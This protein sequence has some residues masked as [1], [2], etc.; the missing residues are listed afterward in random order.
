MNTERE[1]AALAAQPAASAEPTEQD[2]LILFGMWGWQTADGREFRFEHFKEMAR[3]LVGRYGVPAAAQAPA[4]AGDAQPVAW[5]AAD[6]L[7]S[8]H[9]T[10]ISSLAYMS[11]LD[12]ER[13]REYMPLYTTDRRAS[14]AATNKPSRNSLNWPSDFPMKHEGDSK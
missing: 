11:Q 7:N 10:C 6:T 3:H 8:P 14:S 2:L 4:A 9:P 13:G 12:R 1:R 5:V